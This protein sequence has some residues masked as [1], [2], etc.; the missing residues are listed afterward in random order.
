MCVTSPY[1]VDV[2][3]YNSEAVVTDYRHMHNDTGDFS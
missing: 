1:L 3:Q 2:F